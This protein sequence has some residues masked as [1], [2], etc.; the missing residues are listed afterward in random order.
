MIVGKKLIFAEEGR[1]RGE[2]HKMEGLVLVV[3]VVG[4]WSGVEGRG[5]SELDEK[6]LP[7]PPISS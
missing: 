6:P 7:F 4:E 5:R 2:Y 1:R 3:V